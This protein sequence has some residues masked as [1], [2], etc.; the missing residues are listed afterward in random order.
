MAT[1]KSEGALGRPGWKGTM[2][3][4]RPKRVAT[5]LPGLRA[6]SRA[7]WKVSLGA[8]PPGGVA[9]VKSWPQGSVEP[10]APVELTQTE[11]MLAR[12]LSSAWGR[13]RPV[14]AAAAR[15]LP[16]AVSTRLLAGPKAL[17]RPTRL[18]DDAP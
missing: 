5:L 1:A 17:L 11:R 9:A 10:V 16:V 13:T 8:E 6:M 12:V 3:P 15:A 14:I 18:V 4:E 7:A 2:A